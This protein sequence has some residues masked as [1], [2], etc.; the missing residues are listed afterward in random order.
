MTYGHIQYDGLYKHKR[1]LNV[2]CRFDLNQSVD[3]TL[4]FLNCCRFVDKYFSLKKVQ[5]VD[6]QVEKMKICRLK[7]FYPKH[8]D[9]RFS[10]IENVNYDIDASVEDP[11]SMDYMD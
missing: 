4:Y 11:N 9:C 2:D 10:K 5:V 7:M 3:S 8:V 6:Y 1:W